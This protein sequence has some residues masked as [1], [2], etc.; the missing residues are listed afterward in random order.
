MQ[1]NFGL[2]TGLMQLAGI[3]LLTLG[4]YMLFGALA[5]V[6]TGGGIVLLALLIEYANMEKE[7]KPVATTNG[8]EVLR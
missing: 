3:A 6:G 4:L 8:R 1:I 5:L 2:V 7:V